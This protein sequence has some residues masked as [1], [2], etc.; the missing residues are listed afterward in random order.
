[1]IQY[2]ELCNLIPLDGKESSALGQLAWSSPSGSSPDI[3]RSS[4]QPQECG[5]TVIINSESVTSPLMICNG[6][7]IYYW[8]LYQYKG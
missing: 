1:M 6:R 3:K 7:D 4:A 8:Y 2:V 5:K